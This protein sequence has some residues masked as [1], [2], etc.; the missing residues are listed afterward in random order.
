[1]Q[2]ER[3]SQLARLHKITDKS[4]PETTE[5]I[6]DS[7]GSLPQY[8]WQSITFDNGLE[9]ASHC[10]LK[11]DYQLKTYFGDA[12]AAWQKGGVE[13]LNG[14]IRQSIPK[15]SDISK[16]T[17]DQ[18]YAIQEKLNNRPRKSLN[19]LTPNQVIDQETGQGGFI[20]IKNY[21]SLIDCF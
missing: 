1:M 14:L 13:N 3:K 2:Y 4:A 12:Y 17:D 8:L 5:A 10:Q 20:L 11:N 19:Y 15:G 16:L 18:I 21:L 7:I 6:R 9:G